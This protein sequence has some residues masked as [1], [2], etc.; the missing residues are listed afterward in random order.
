[1]ETR[2][3]ATNFFVDYLPTGEYTLEYDQRATQTGYF[4]AG[5]ATIQSMYAPEFGAQ[6]EGIKLQ[7]QE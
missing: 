6:S 2:D 1:M 5:L 4:S 3:A 7:I